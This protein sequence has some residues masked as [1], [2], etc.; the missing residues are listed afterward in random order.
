MIPCALYLRYSTDRQNERSPEDQEAVCRAWLERNGYSVAAI[1]VDRAKSGASIHDRHDFQRMLRDARSGLFKDVCAETTSRYGRDEEDRAAARK[2]LTFNSITIL[3]PVDGVVTRMIDGMKAVMDAHQLEDLKVMIRR[4]MSAVVREGRH[5]GGTAYGYRPILGKPGELEIVPAEAEIV[6]RIYAEYIRGASARAIVARLNSEGVP[7]PR[8]H[9]WR[10]ITLVGH[11]RRRTGV[12]QC[13]LYTGHIVWNRAYRVRNPDTGR[14]EWRYWPETEWIRSD[15]PHL[16]IIDDGIFDAAQKSRQKR[17][18]SA[19]RDRQSPK[20]ILSGLL[21]CGCCNAGMSKRDNDHGR[22]R[23]VC[24]RMIESKTCD[25]RR[26]YYLDDIEHRVI[27]G[28]RAELGT[29]EAIAYYIRCYNEERRRASSGGEDLRRS[30]QAQAA[31]VEK[32]LHR[33]VQAVIEER[34]T[35]AEADQHLPALRAKLTDIRIQLAAAGAEPKVVTLQPAAVSSYL[36]DLDRLEEVVNSQLAAGDEGAA[37]AIRSL[38]DTVTIVQSPAPSL[39]TIIV[40]GRLQA[41]MAPDVCPDGVYAGGRPVPDERIELPTNGLQNRCSTAE[42]IRLARHIVQ[43]Q[44]AWESAPGRENQCPGGGAMVPAG[45][46]IPGGMVPGG[47]VPGVIP[48]GGAIIPPGAPEAPRFLASR[49][50][51]FMPLGMI[52]SPGR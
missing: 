18:R 19:P 11:T 49:M 39:P 6:K 1:Y 36:R 10:A 7:A 41:L 50:L 48:G 52:M 22:P 17:S 32:Q 5:N 46:I 30:L 35:Q 47:M 20:R 23:I 44:P 37:K 12:L 38:V 2:R 43:I 21:R 9:F 3:T 45:G 14:R 27:C 26:R 42:L 40:R 16:R 29:R 8:G 34:I 15:A 33:A 13:E 31:T 25:N 4:G 51:I 28:L 24:T